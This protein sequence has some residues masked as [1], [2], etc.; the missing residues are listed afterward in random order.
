MTEPKGLSPIMTKAYMAL[1]SDEEREDFL[2][3]LK[4]LHSSS[5]RTAVA[6]IMARNLSHGAGKHLL[7]SKIYPK[8][9]E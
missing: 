3:Q 6:A 9:N 4:N 8:D 1:S 5:V 7:N 2:K